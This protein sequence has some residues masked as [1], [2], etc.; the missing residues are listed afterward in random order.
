MNI[1]Q[2]A[3]ASFE[4]HGIPTLTPQSV[5]EEYTFFSASG[6]EITMVKTRVNMPSRKLDIKIQWE[7]NEVIHE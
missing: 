3:I 2:S 7:D 1:P 4:P 6:V 5:T